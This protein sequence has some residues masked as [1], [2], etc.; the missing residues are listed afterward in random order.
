MKRRHQL[1]KPA[2]PLILAV[3]LGCATVISHQAAPDDWPQLERRE[4]RVGFLEVQRLCAPARQNMSV[5]GWLWSLGLAGECTLIDF[6][7][8]ICWHVRPID[9]T[10]SGFD[11]HELEHCAGKDHVGESV[12]RDAWAA[13]K[14]SK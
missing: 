13:Y 9:E 1:A 5:A 12:L 4:V 3:L 14:R 2:S 7:K 11:D 10:D 6:D 8:R